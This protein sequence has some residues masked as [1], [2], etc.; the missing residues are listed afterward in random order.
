ML[1]RK[2][3]GDVAVDGSFDAGAAEA[4][5]VD[6]GDEVERE[7]PQGPA[8]LTLHAHE[9]RGAPSVRLPPRT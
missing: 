8:C 6:E 5:W 1:G 2:G 4:V 7:T 3:H 9:E